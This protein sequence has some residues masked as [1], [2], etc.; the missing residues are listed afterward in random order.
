MHEYLAPATL[1][2]AMRAG[3]GLNRR[4]IPGL[5]VTWITGSMK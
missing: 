1:L 4:D 3:I 2:T 5:K